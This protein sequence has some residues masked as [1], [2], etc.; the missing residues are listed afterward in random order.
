MRTSYAS[1]VVLF[2]FVVGLPLAPLSAQESGKPEPKPSQDKWLPLFNGKDL[3]GWKEV[4]KE[5][6]WMVENGILTSQGKQENYLFTEK[7]DFQNFHLRVE[8]RINEGGN[9]GLM[10]RSLFGPG[11]PI[12]YEAQIEN[13]GKSFRTG[14]LVKMLLPKATA[15]CLV[16][17]KEVL[18]KPSEWFVEEV[19]AEGNRIR[20]KVNDKLVA[21]YVDAE[22]PYTKGHVALQQFTG[23]TVVQFRKIEL[24]EL[25][26][27]LAQK[28]AWNHL[29]L[30][31]GKVMGDFVRI[32]PDKAVATKKAYSGPVEI[33]V[34]ARTNKDNIRLWAFKGG[35]VIFNWDVEPGDMRIHRPDDLEKEQVGSVA[36]SKQVPLKPDTWYTLRWKITEEGMEVAVDNKVVFSEEREYDLSK[37]RPIRVSGA[38]GSVVDVKS[39][40]VVTL[41]AKKPAVV[42]AK[43]SQ[44]P[45]V[46]E[47]H[48]GAVTALLFSP[49]GKVMMTGGDDGNVVLWELPSLKK[50]DTIRNCPT[51]SLAISP[52]GKTLVAGSGAAPTA[53]IWDVEKRKKVTSLQWKAGD[54]GAANVAFS[55]DGKELVVGV[56]QLPG[57]DFMW[58]GSLYLV[59]TENWKVK[60]SFGRTLALPGLALSPDGKTLVVDGSD[61]IIE[62]DLATRKPRNV[63]P[64]IGFTYGFSSLAF[65]PDGKY[66]ASGRSFLGRAPE[67]GQVRQGRLIME[68]V[69]PKGKPLWKDIKK[70]N[71]GISVAF[72]PD[73]KLFAAGI[74]GSER[75][76]GELILWH[77]ETKEEITALKHTTPVNCIAFSPDGSL[78]A[79]GVGAKVLVYK[80]VRGE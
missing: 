32:N 18:A 12:G 24:K 8:A 7:G 5:S 77:T 57:V 72:S 54:G 13:S 63:D 17:V 55:P 42:Q 23:D 61:S 25:N 71:N 36:V 69:P 51:H 29:D 44:P 14:S 70:N 46:L 35:I 68:A 75:A 60:H 58:Q 66:K 78:L 15:S 20:I 45:T 19:I 26:L 43:L 59:D 38:F 31:D 4:G 1:T 65:S 49:N 56:S 52:N 28:P 41:A 3:S 80:I 33:T 2:M 62:I 10:F 39:F 67:G 48:K 30:T 22:S 50:L 76:A 73:S 11:L 47:E 74:A 27:T 64:Y 16:D 9:S 6:N 21:D 53:E 37:A 34:V 79:A 40:V